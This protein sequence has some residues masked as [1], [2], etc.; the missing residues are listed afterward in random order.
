MLIKSRTVQKLQCICMATKTLHLLHVLVVAVAVCLACCEKVIHVHKNGV[1]SPNCLAALPPNQFTPQVFCKTLWYVSVNGN[2]SMDNVTIAIETSVK[3][4]A[5]AIFKASPFIKIQ[6]MFTQ[7]T[8]HCNCNSASRRGIIVHHVQ[9]FMISNVTM[10]NCCGQFKEWIA[11]LQFHHCGSVMI[12]NVKITQSKWNTGLIIIDSHK[13]INIHESIFSNNGFTKPVITH[14]LAGGIYLLLNQKVNVSISQCVI[15]HNHSPSNAQSTN[16]SGS[17]LGGGLGLILSTMC[18]NANVHIQNCSF[19]ANR[20]NWGAGLCTHFQRNTS[21][22]RIIVLNSIFMS[23]QARGGGGGV[24]VNL[25]RLH[26]FEHRNIILFRNVSFQQN[27]GGQFGGGTSVTAKFSSYTSQPGEL[28]QFINCSWIE[29]YSRYGAAVD[30]SPSIFEESYQGFLPIPIFKDNLI[31]GNHPGNTLSNQLHITQGA[32]TVTLFT[33]NF[34]GTHTF[35]KNWYSALYLTSGQITF[36]SN[37]NVLFHSNYGIKG[38]A[39]VAY[40]FSTIYVKDN[41]SIVFFNNSASQVG[42][43]IYHISINQ[44][45]Y[46]AG[47][48]CFLKYEGNESRPELR[49]ITFTFTNNSAQR[50]TSIFSESLQSC[51][52]AHLGFSSH[53]N[54]LTSLFDKLWSFQFNEPVTSALATGARYVTFE[55]DSP[56][57]TTPGNEINLPLAMYDEFCHRMK[58]KY[59]LN[60]NDNDNVNLYKYYTVTNRTRVLGAPHQNATLTL[61]TV[62]SL[63]N[64]DY[65]VKI[66]LTQCPPGFF[67]STPSN[68]CRCSADVE[69]QTYV[70]IVK[71]NYTKYRAFILN[72]YWAGYI[73]SEIQHPNN[74]YTALYPSTYHNTYR[75]NSR[76]M[77]NNGKNLTQF[78]CENSRKGIICG[79]CQED[80]SPYYHARGF[81]CG[82]VTLCRFGLIFYFL[83]EIIPVTILFSIVMIYGV[84]F[85]SGNLNGFILFSQ[86]FDSFSESITISELYNSSVVTVLQD[87]YK[88]IYGIFNFEFFPSFP[89]CLW[90]GAFILDLLVF[91]YATTAFAFILLFLIV[92]IMNFSSKR[93]ICLKRFKLFTERRISIT[94]GISTFFV[95]TY[96][97]CTSVS[98]AILR[99][100]HLQ[101]KPGVQPISIS[102]YGGLPFLGKKHL[103]YAIP[104]VVICLTFV[105]LP[106]LCLIIYPSILHLLAFCGLSEHPVVSKILLFIRI[107]RLKPLFDSSQGCYKDKLRFFSGMYFLYRVLVLVAK[108]AS[109]SDTQFFIVLEFLA[110]VMLGIHSVFQPYKLTKH[111]I[112]D[113]LLF[114]NFAVI[115]GITIIIKLSPTAKHEFDTFSITLVQLFFIYLPI[116]SLFFMLLLKPAAEKIYKKCSKYR[117]RTTS[118]T[119]TDQTPVSVMTIGV[120]HNSIELR[121]SLLMK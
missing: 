10:N 26:K 100:V 105:S 1:D 43:A 38:G 81:I 52:Y 30:V 39:I 88:F 3:V 83:S 31:V 115:N 61:S 73:P 110:L 19:I 72:G 54:T 2:Y 87:G 108:M 6:G 116:A 47:R 96:A 20:A 36:E 79:E 77:P 113:S 7:R 16:W 23:N 58:S 109:D 44:K 41:S 93:C 71:C 53:K 33:V 45:D 95:V 99:R 66:E 55:K 94:H 97:Q 59:T 90:E 37:S 98:F 32:F 106:P 101:G 15:E 50:G 82:Q 86:V 111:N 25:G 68:T 74:L 35:H 117:S 57:Q 8:L 103:V 49:S 63:Y 21:K 4:N 13:N 62:Q 78:F 67:Y 48:T 85:S 69:P 51:Y 34:E 24:S 119:V 65:R 118:G 76:L 84:S 104:A 102:Y 29:N 11:S 75:S 18:K 60:I 22:N 91:K 5:L 9:I 40:G 121:E 89:F 112:I 120:T 14:S 114:L 92:G 107:D 70:A 12:E 46:F 64:I 56:L 42:G 80:Y 28:I 17:S 27:K